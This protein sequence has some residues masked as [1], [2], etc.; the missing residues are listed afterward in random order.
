MLE[1]DIVHKF[2]KVNV[3]E[4]ITYFN[5]ERFEDL[6]RWIMLFDL[7]EATS[8]IKSNKKEKRLNVTEMNR[9]INK[10]LKTISDDLSLLV[11][12]AETCGYDFIKFKNEIE[13]SRN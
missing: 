1:E 4:G 12:K 2:I 11:K 7:I 10:S 13:I 5:K 9:E 8:S 6:I 3:F